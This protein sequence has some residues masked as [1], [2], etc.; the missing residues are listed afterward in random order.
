MRIPLVLVLLAA[1]LAVAVS[2]A[3]AAPRAVTV[4]SQ[5]LTAAVVG[6]INVVR[7]AHGLAALRVS[8]QLSAAAAQHSGEMA[9]IGYFSHDSA[10]GGA[11]WARVKRYYPRGGHRLW[12]VGENLVWASPG[13]G[14]AGALQ[15]WMASPEHRANLLSAR[16]REVGVSAVHAG[17]AP[18]VYGGG[19]VTVVTADFGVRR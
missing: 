5:T 10:G 19:A 11:F 9:R 17:S 4:R 18:G 15:M 1:T 7:R 2:P 8:S 3:P 16:W 6:Q 13:L 14:A 12:S